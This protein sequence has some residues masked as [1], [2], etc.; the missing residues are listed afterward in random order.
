[1]KIKLLLISC[2]AIALQ[3]NCLSQCPGLNSPLSSYEGDGRRDFFTRIKFKE[4]LQKLPAPIHAEDFKITAQNMHTVLSA[5]AAPNKNYDGVRIY[6]IVSNKNVPN[7]YDKNTIYLVFVPTTDGQT[8]DDDGEEIS[9]DDYSNAYVITKNG[10]P[11]PVDL[12]DAANKYILNWMNRFQN[13]LIHRINAKFKNRFGIE[14]S[15]TLSLWFNKS[16]LFSSRDEKDLL[17][18]LNNKDCNI[19]SVNID[20]ASWNV[21]ADEPDFSFKNDLLFEIVKANNTSDYFTLGT[22]EINLYK[23]KLIEDQS[24]LNKDLPSYEDDYKKLQKEIDIL[25]GQEYTDTGNPCP[26]KKCP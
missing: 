5:F 20:F 9:D 11:K 14:L 21:N 2:F 26:A 17:A 25:S 10:I 8:T 4:I 19:I 12:S 16:V 15:E 7:M 1:M 6:F 18:N 3:Y 13:Q 23:K 22:P 24:K